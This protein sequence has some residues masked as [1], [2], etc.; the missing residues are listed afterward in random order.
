LSGTNTFN[1]G[2]FPPNNV[3]DASPTKRQIPTT[4]RPVG[5][6]FSQIEVDDDVKE[7]AIFASTAIA[8]K[9]NSGPARVTKI[10]KAESQIVA[11][12]NYKLTLELNQP[13]ATE[14]FIICDVLVFDQSW[15][16]TRI[17]SEHN[18]K[19]NTNPSTTTEIA[20]GKNKTSGVLT[21][22]EKDSLP[23]REVPITTSSN[24][25]KFSAIDVDDPDVKEVAEF[26][27]K[28]ANT[29]AATSGHSAPVKLV[30]ILK[31]EWQI[32]DAIGRNFKLTLELD[33]GAEESLLCVV[34]VFEQS[35]WKSNSTWTNT[36][37]L[38]ESTCFAT[39]RST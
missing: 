1:S 26:A 39:R 37:S 29:A 31:A 9:R 17:L 25:N 33:D 8:S 20:V 21:S 28:V 15:T 23:K 35:T 7:I 3:A 34:S 5:G 27:M 4:Q 18:C 2:L 6:G 13:L 12:T 24:T 16:K 36:R 32:V 14:K 19:V 10:A 30:K 22:S 38:T 11:G